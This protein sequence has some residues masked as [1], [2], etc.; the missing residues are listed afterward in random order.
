MTTIA[1]G[2]FGESVGR[3]AG[4]ALAHLHGRSETQR[5]Q[6]P[7]RVSQH[8]ALLAP[9]KL[10]RMFV[11]TVMGLRTGAVMAVDRPADADF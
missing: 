3:E 4:G 1:A 2:A 5:S 11:T 8:I 7:E 9:T 6:G 10:E